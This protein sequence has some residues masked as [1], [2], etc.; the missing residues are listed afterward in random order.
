MKK[1]AREATRIY[2]KKLYSDKKLFQK[3]SSWLEKPNA[4]IIAVVKNNFIGKKHIK[5]LDLGAGVGR[6]A[7]PIAKIIGKSG[8]KVTCVD[9]LDVAIDKL[10]EYVKEHN[11]G[12][13]IKGFVSSIEDF[14]INPNTYD[15]IVAH[16]VLTHTRSKEKMVQIIKDIAKG[17]RKNGIVYIYMITN[18][19]EFDSE[20]GKEQDPEAEVEINFKEASALLKDIYKGW[21]IQALKKIPYEEKYKK[22]GKVVRWQVDYLLFIAKAGITR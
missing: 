12:K 4:E 19:R 21:T 16:S 1:R 7:I 20:T 14:I 15:F 10:N 5:V 9:Y 17:T 8:G 22:R 2:H 18:S 11:V 3:G 13:F 6:N